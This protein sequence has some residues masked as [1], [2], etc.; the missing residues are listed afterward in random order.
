[1]TK[2]S[3]VQRLWIS[4]LHITD[5]TYRIGDRLLFDQATVRIP[6]GHKVGFVGKNGAGKSTLFRM[7]LDEFGPESGA[8]KVRSNAIV[9]HVGQEAPG[10][11]QSLLETVLNSHREMADLKVELSQTEQ[12][13]R[14]AEI[15][16]RLTDLG[17]HSAEARAAKIL[18]G[19][20]FDEVAQ[21]RSCESYSGGWR[22]RVAL[23]CMLFQEPDL[24]L[25]DEPTNYLDIEGV[26]WLENFLKSYPYTVIIISHDRDLLNKAV[27]S[28]V[29]L[30]QGK[31]NFYTGG[32]DRFEEMRRLKIEQQMALK[33][34]QEAERRH[35]QSFVDRF[36]AK[37]SKAKQAQ[38]RVKML[39]R[40]KPIASIVEEHTIPFQFPH[41]EPLSSPL[42]ALENVSVG[43]DPET[44]IL[45]KLNLRIDMD[46]RIALLG[47]NGNG[48]STFAKLLCEKL[49]P[50]NFEEGG[51]YRRPRKLKIG[52]FAQHQLDEINP[53]DTPLH[54][55]QR[56]MPEEA[57]EAQ[58]RARLGSFGFGIDKA[59]RKVESLSGGEKARLMFAVCTFDKPQ[60]LI[61][62]EPTN[63][64]DVD[65][66]EALALALNDY[67]GAVV[68]ISHDRHLVEACADR[69][70]IVKEGDVAPYDGDLEDYKKLLLSERSGERRKDKKD[71]LKK[72]DRISGAQAR[73]AIAPLRKAVKV[74]EAALDKL[75]KEKRR[76]ESKL[77]DPKL[78]ESEDPRAGPLIIKLNKQAGELTVAIEDAEIAWMEAEEKLAEVTD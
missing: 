3:A 30:E 24:L 63:H 6:V 42:I 35:I 37:A 61:L 68:L 9:G 40:M 58:I 34:K 44:V 28:I 4:M 43:Y 5:I 18:S 17:Y 76:V 38:S 27:N 77:A 11:P 25:L 60:L 12:G 23:A 55:M 73:A 41:P 7:I 64:L 14:I 22:M 46:D 56:L 1:M 39:E 32:Y 69:L 8:I 33:T 10:G 74:A 19:L 31:L 16:A 57:T 51:R 71:D 75:E 36:K 49:K 78:Y 66:R 29:H 50:L 47:A 2:F 26:I 13:E 52:Y 48:K 15:H 21:L 45:N 59:D 67:D 70:W 62:D 54:I 20:G 65:S 72:Q 53:S